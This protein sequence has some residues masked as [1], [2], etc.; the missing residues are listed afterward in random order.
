M[1]TYGHI[2]L[3]ATTGGIILKEDDR[4]WLNP[5]NEEIKKKVIEAK[6][7]LKDKAVSILTDE[8]GKYLSVTLSEENEVGYDEE[9]FVE[10]DIDIEA[11][12]QLDNK[13]AEEKPKINFSGVKLEVPKDVKKPEENYFTNLNKVPCK[14]EKKAGLNYISWAEAWAKLKEI[15][16]EA[17]YEIY[18]NENGLPYFRDECGVFAK[19]GVYVNEIEHIMI[20]PVL[21]HL[22]KPVEKP[23]AFLIN[24]TIMRCFAKAISMHGLGTYVFLG[25]D[26]PSEKDQA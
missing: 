2:K 1:A 17:Q 25:E 4:N 24:K 12:N 10:E 26:F 18:C 22:N 11:D 15:H 14:V 3:V 9:E 19:V 13:L 16:P 20:L 7:H 23:D 21:N 8:S 5:A 6:D